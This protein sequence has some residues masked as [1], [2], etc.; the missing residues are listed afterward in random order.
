VRLSQPEPPRQNDGR[1][2]D[3]TSDRP[4]PLSLP[5]LIRNDLND[6]IQRGSARTKPIGEQICFIRNPHTQHPAQALDLEHRPTQLTEAR[7]RRHAQ[8]GSFHD[9]LTPQSRTYAERNRS[10]ISSRCPASSWW[11]AVPDV[12]T[13]MQG[14]CSQLCKSPCGCT[15]SSI[16]QA[17]PQHFSMTF[18]PP[19]LRT[20]CKLPRQR[21]P[22][23][24]PRRPVFLP[25]DSCFAATHHL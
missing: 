4:R 8:I 6:R 23:P 9:I 19:R 14:R 3:P 25:L 20:F 1:S 13:H 16:R 24:I 17:L 10:P 21:P 2:I 5:P 7:A 22:C 12:R 15:Q 11:R 18:H